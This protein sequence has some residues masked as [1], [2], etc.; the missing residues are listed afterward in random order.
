MTGQKGPRLK[1]HLNDLMAAKG[2]SGKKLAADAAVTER[3]I[4]V[5]RKNQA[6]LLDINTV[7]RICVAIGASPGD[8]FSI[9]EPIENE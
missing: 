8:L 2:V 6:Q 1:S 4:S 9:E 3:A 7:A 5:L